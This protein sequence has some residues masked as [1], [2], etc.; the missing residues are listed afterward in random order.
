MFAVK[1]ECTERRMGNG[2]GEYCCPANDGGRESMKSEGMVCAV[3]G[4]II[5]EHGV[6]DCS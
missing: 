3:Q 1:Y 4:N 2:G 6:S 5:V